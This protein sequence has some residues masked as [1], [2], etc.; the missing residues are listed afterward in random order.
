MADSI[1]AAQV[2]NERHLE[3]ALARRVIL[4]PTKQSANECIECGD[5]IPSARQIA[6]PGVE[7]CVHRQSLIEIKAKR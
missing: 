5:Q 6:L 3:L 2:E 1:D 4:D 7:T